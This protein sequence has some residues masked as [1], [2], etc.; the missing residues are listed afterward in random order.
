LHLFGDSSD[1]H[2]AH[3][4]AH[5]E[6][7]SVELFWEVRNTTELRWRVLR[8]ESDYATT[9]DALPHSRR[10]RPPEQPE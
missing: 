7:G 6:R 2:L 4:H 9:A 5:R 8:S 10:H 1:P 3:F